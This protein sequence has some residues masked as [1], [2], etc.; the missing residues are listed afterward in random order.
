M[1][2]E[3]EKSL[4]RYLKRKV[5][6]TLGFV[7]AFAIMGNVGMANDVAINPEDL[8]NYEKSEYYLKGLGSSTINI[9]GEIQY[10]SE[11]IKVN[12][13]QDTD[14]YKITYSNNI[15]NIINNY[16]YQPVLKKLTLSKKYLSG[17]TAKKVNSILDAEGKIYSNISSSLNRDVASNELIVGN[18]DVV[19]QTV[20]GTENVMNNGYIIGQKGQKVEDGNAINNGV[21][22]TYNEAQTATGVGD[23]I[24]YGYIFSSNGTAQIGNDGN[25]YNYGLINSR[26]GQQLKQGGLGNIYN[27]GVIKTTDT[28]SSMYRYQGQFLDG[29][30]EGYNEAYNFGIIEVLIHG[31]Y[32]QLGRGTNKLYNYGLINV[33]SENGSAISPNGATSYNY[34][35]VKVN[36]GLGV[37]TSG[38]V[39]NEGV[40]HALGESDIF[41]DKLTI[42]NTGIIITSKDVSDKEWAKTGVTLNSDYTL[43]N[44][45]A[46]T[47]ITTERL[48]DT[49]FGEKNIGYIHS[50]Q[51]ND[52][53][54]T[55]GDISEKTLGVVV[56]NKNTNPVF[57]LD[58]NTLIQDS[59][60]TGY[61]ING[62]TFIDMN[63]KNLIL[64]NTSVSVVEDLQKTNGERAVAIDLGD[65]GNLSLMG[66]S[67][68]NGIIKGG[69]NSS[70]ETVAQK[71]NLSTDGIETL[72]LKNGNADIEEINYTEVNLSDGNV[73]K[74]HSEFL[75]TS[76]GKENTITIAGNFIVGDE[77][78]DYK[79]ND[80]IVDNSV[81]GMK[82]NYV[83][84]NLDNIYGN[85]KLGDGENTLTVSNN[86]EYNYD[87][88]INLG[89][90]D[91]DT[92]IAK[93]TGSDINKFNFHITNA[94]NV[95]LNGGKWKIGDGTLDFT[96]VSSSNSR[97]SRELDL[98]MTGNSTFYITLNS[99]RGGSDLSNAV[100]RGLITRD[101]DLI[102]STDE[103]S[104]I[105]YQIS[106]NGLDFNQLSTDNYSISTDANVVAPIFNV[107]S[108][109]KNGVSMTVKTA[110]EVGV[111]NYKPIYDAI[112]NGLSADIANE[113]VIDKINGMNETG[114]VANFVKN[115]ST[116]AQ[117][118]YTAG[119]IV[120]KNITDSYV[121]AVED[122]GKKA[123]KGEWIT[124]AKYINSNTE[125]DGGNKVK[126]YD[127]DI[128][129]AVGIIEYGITD[130]TS[131][132]AVF[133]G[134]K[135]NID[136][137][138]GGSLEGD[139][140]YLGAYVKHK[141]ENNIDIVGNIG[142]IKSDLDSKLTQEFKFTSGNINLNGKSNVDG[143]ADSSAITASVMAKKNYYVTDTVRLEPLTSLRYTLIKQDT[144][145]NKDM[146]FSIQKQDASVFEATVG[147]N[148]VKELRLEKGLLEL[149]AGVKYTFAGTS[150]DE[151]VRYNLYSSQDLSLT[152]EGAELGDNKGTAFIG[153]GYEHENGIGFNGKYE[154]IWSDSGDDSRFTAGLSYRF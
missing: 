147:L 20:A 58:D 119:T 125:F 146:G 9:T 51:N 46:A 124:T 41:S 106:E 149:N 56:E 81:E 96:N 87:G 19:V 33:T 72:E 108:D 25:I 5:R 65:G 11:E 151:D 105:K 24:N 48:D 66:D 2:K 85:I 135:T 64:S 140:F 123:N 128:N 67:Q 93:A 76:E 118:Y 153:I 59:N 82:V 10:G 30:W 55:L 109:G 75:K 114:E 47:T 143:T 15:N 13:S 88:E 115:I 84:E 3:L 101:V 44:T 130:N 90:G 52:S 102:L 137:N 6:I 138:G 54:I 139:N 38:K 70:V 79:T 129:S 126:G 29:V 73:D 14:N 27:Y 69:N 18:K 142:I 77:S 97:A 112:V 91:N 131:Y 95:E 113:N 132:G 4:K 92:F 150:E 53:S 86:E 89:I 116:G 62:G 117:A 37:A 78:G 34:G 7:T 36:K 94:E 111:S 121:S 133:G 17:E 23:I 154:M 26:Y 60:L 16:G 49:S 83:I 98:K 22:T 80:V 100:E 57:I 42:D 127:G 8:T 21:L 63:G 74:I 110:D 32:S 12:I 71:G 104:K 39:I 61:L 28:E 50:N 152:L 99:E 45:D 148:T 1:K 141:T 136:I 145:E 120:T 122:F 107:S 68:V 134:G 103:E 40:I 31:Q 43:Q 35:L 144:A